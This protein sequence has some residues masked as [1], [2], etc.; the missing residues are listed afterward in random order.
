MNKP[1]VFV[2]M[3]FDPAFNDVYKLGIKAACSES[4]MYSERVDE[5]HYEGRI[6]DRI[7]NQINKADYII[8]DMSGR[9]ANVFYETGY[10]HALQKKVIL[11]VNSTDDIPFD[12]KHHPHIIYN[13]SISHLKDELVNRLKWFSD[14]PERKSEPNVEGLKFSL[15]G[16]LVEKDCSI[17][18]ATEYNFIEQAFWLRLDVLNQSN[19]SI[20]ETLEFGLQTLFK[21]ELYEFNEDGN[22]VSIPEVGI[23]FY[24]GKIEK[25]FPN[26][27]KVISFKVTPKDY[28]NAVKISSN[29]ILKIYSELY[30]YEIPFRLT[31]LQRGKDFGKF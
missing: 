15:Q 27:S 10:A 4:G 29:V 28:R 13:S 11:V 30:T 3:P 22:N 26:H 24:I 2:L 8:A 6:L 16:K 9:N 5:Q 7:Y 23:Q 20:K 18:Y 31:I 12:L 14:N 21:D 25:L 1:F 19:V 17:L